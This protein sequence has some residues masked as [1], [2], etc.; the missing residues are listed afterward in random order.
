M[1][2][3]ARITLITLLVISFSVTIYADDFDDRAAD[4]EEKK[5]L[6]SKELV[7]TVVFFFGGLAFLLCLV[8]LSWKWECPKC[9]KNFA[10]KTIAKTKLEPYLYKYRYRCKYCNY[11][12]QETKDTT[13]I[14]IP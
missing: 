12:F 2:A 7:S 5:V 3:L 4:Q 11:E 13:P 14:W 8:S 6:D 1:K 9:H 10:I